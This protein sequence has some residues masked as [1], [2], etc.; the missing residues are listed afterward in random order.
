M[1]PDLERLIRFQRLEDS[2]AEARSKI[3]LHPTRL[4]DLDARI[5]ERTRDVDA[6]KQ[7]LA[8]QRA[9]RQSLEKELA[10]VQTRLSRFKEQ[11][12]EVK[13]NKEYQAMQTEMAGA[14][15]EVR[16]LED[17]ILE[18]ML[19]GDELAAEVAQVEQA[20]AAEQ[21]LVAKERDALEDERRDLERRLG[22]YGEA[23]AKLAGEVAPQAMALFETVARQRKGVAVVE[24]R[25]GHCSSCQV[26]LR[27][28]LFN[29]IRSNSSLIQCESCQRIL[30]YKAEQ[31]LAS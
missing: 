28:Q 12:M 13:T 2:A 11:L 24:A 26:R 25:N 21:D 31:G 18:R 20:L 30:F 17:A 14:E 22:Q 3:D 10:S 5:A 19:E 9:D 29:D 1:V 27:P 7:R 4:E 8:D 23:R 16:R 15:T 6:A